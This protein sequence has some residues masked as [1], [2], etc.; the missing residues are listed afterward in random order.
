MTVQLNSGGTAEAAEVMIHIHNKSTVS[1]QQGRPREPFT[2]W[3]IGGG[4]AV[5]GQ[6]RP[7]RSWFWIFVREELHP[8][9]GVKRFLPAELQTPWVIICYLQI[10][11]RLDWTLVSVRAPL[12]SLLCIFKCFIQV[13]KMYWGLN[14]VV[15]R[16]TGAQ[17]QTNPTGTWGVSCF[18]NRDQPKLL[19]GLGLVLGSGIRGSGQSETWGSGRSWASTSARRDFWHDVIM[20]HD[21]L[22]HSFV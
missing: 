9:L 14:K 20:S 6:L 12:R 10:I 17:Q 16:Q 18:C 21:Q 8:P 15:G 13:K 11:Y 4:G 5:R 1:P 22:T 2:G 19:T 3:S 7:P